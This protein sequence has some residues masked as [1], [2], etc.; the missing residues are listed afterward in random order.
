[1]FMGLSILGVILGTGLAC[2]AEFV[3]ARATFETWG[4]TF[5]VAGL[6]LLGAGLPVF[7]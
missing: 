7:H 3:P 4:G 1:M 6:A 5:L 2:T